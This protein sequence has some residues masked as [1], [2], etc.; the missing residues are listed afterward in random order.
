MRI[1]TDLPGDRLTPLQLVTVSQGNILKNKSKSNGFIVATAA[2]LTFLLV[3]CG[4]TDT[5]KE[6]RADPTQLSIGQKSSADGQ[7]IDTNP[8]THQTGN[9][10][11]GRRFETFGNHPTSQRRTLLEADLIRALEV[12]R[13]ADIKAIDPQM[14]TK[15]VEELKTGGSP[16]LNT[17]ERSV[18]RR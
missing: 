16:S 12:V 3:G 9:A 18:A 10:Q 17:E 13:Q 11:R 15:L 4:S 5:D 1:S 14:R 8:F 6:S 7:G 2:A